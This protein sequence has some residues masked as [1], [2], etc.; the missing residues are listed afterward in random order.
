MEDNI[1]IDFKEVE[2]EGMFW[3]RLVRDLSAAG[4]C[5]NG[6]EYWGFTKR[7]IF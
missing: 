6:K 3:M 1:K 5:E 2:C 7:K 4:Y